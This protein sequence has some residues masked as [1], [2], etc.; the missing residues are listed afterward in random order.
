MQTED[1]IDVTWLKNGTNLIYDVGNW[2]SEAWEEEQVIT[3][4]P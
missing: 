1:V 2:R 3:Y 4:P